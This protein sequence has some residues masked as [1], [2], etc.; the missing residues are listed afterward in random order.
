[1]NAPENIAKI[2]STALSASPLATQVAA[3]FD[4]LELSFDD[5][6]G[7]DL[8]VFSPIDGSQLAALRMDTPGDVDA[9]VANA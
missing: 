9:M 3:T 6:L 1:M 5:R 7:S 4:Q 8:T 2:T